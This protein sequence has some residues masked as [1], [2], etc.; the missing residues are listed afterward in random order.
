VS[1]SVA[2]SGRPA[3]AAL[4]AIDVR[5]AGVTVTGVVP[6]TPVAESF[7]DTVAVPT[8]R[9]VPSPLDPAAFETA[10]RFAADDDQVTVCVTSCVVPSV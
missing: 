9:A 1:C 10:K 2:P 8:V 5:T 7:A 3:A 4:R 6:L